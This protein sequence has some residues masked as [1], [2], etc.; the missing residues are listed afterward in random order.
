MTFQTILS[1]GEKKISAQK[2][3]LIVQSEIENLLAVTKEA[4]DKVWPE[5]RAMAYFYLERT[6]RDIIDMPHTE[7]VAYVQRVYEDEFVKPMTQ[8]LQS[9][10]GDERAKQVMEVEIWIC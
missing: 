3:I 7:K 9:T 10:L 8:V 4:L 2:D 6:D 1:L 5:F